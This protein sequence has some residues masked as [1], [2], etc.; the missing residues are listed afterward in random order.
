MT[1]PYNDLIANEDRPGT[2]G[3]G[4]LDTAANLLDNVNDGNTLNVTVGGAAFGL[5][6]MSAVA[7]PFKTAMVAGVGWVLEHF[8]PAKTALDKV[9]GDPQAVKN[10][11]ATWG[12]IAAELS[13]AAG[14]V[15]GASTVGGWTGPAADDQKR[16]GDM[17]AKATQAG[18]AGAKD[19]SAVVEGA[20]VAVATTRGLLVD[21]IAEALSK[22]IM[23][24]L[25]AMASA[26]PTF[27]A[28]IGA[29][30]LAIIDLVSDL[31]S[32]ISK[33]LSKLSEVAGNLAKH[34]GDVGGLAAKLEGQLSELAAK[35][36]NK[37]D[38]VH[39]TREDIM[40]MARDR[41]NAEPALDGSWRDYAVPTAKFNDTRDGQILGSTLGGIADAYGSGDPQDA[42]GRAEN[43]ENASTAD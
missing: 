4:I 10:L 21:L 16:V 27:G 29:A 31:F 5:E 34:L 43:V 22:A 8:E 12:N 14:G 15:T 32:K 6:A 35:F 28:S 1:K 17:I 41:F 19:M 23:W 11:A 33:L 42:E 38:S 13:G 18:A 37:A 9:T 26:A 36:A 7:N 2:T 25:A 3:A 20:G 40:P 24:A 39:W 30:V